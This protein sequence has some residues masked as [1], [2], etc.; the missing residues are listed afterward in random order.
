MLPNSFSMLQHINQA[1]KTS[2]IINGLSSLHVL[3]LTAFWVECQLTVLSELFLNYKISIITFHSSEQIESSNAMLARSVK[4][5][6]FIWFCC[7][8]KHLRCFWK[9]FLFSSLVFWVLR[10]L[11][12]YIN[13]LA[14]WYP[15]VFNI[16]CCE[17]FNKWTVNRIKITYKFSM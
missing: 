15:I 3:L 12:F 6:A 14:C 9:V 8:P 4:T 1:I 5:A 11:N 13:R 2:F 10:S 17:N 16:D 7:R